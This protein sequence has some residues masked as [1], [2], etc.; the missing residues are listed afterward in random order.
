MAGSVLDLFAE[1]A[2]VHVD[3][4][5]V[6]VLVLSPDGI[7]QRIAGEHHP[8]VGHQVLECFVLFEG[9]FQ[10][11]AVAGDHVLGDV[12][13][14]V[15]RAQDAR[16]AAALG[17]AAAQHGLHAGN[18]LA[19]AERLGY[20]V[21]G[22]H[23]QADHA[24]HLLHARREDDDRYVAGA[25]DG[26]A[27]LEAAQP[28]KHDVEDDQVRAF[29][30]GKPQALDAVGGGQYPEP[31]AFEG[32]AHRF[33]DRTLVFYDEYGVRHASSRAEAARALPPLN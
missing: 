32:V 19:H 23:L 22:A 29:P 33:R 20:V 15:A 7:E 3:G 8:P 2:D 28:R 21:V 14:Q 18:Q 11:L 9:D 10:R 12:H 6:A 25:A 17:V 5:G 30:L 27:K 16:I 13:L 31:L 1:P 26:A 24:V 4:S